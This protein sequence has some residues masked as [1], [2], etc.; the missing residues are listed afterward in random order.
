M[1][2]IIWLFAFTALYVLFVKVASDRIPGA[3]LSKLFLQVLVINLSSLLEGLKDTFVVE[4]VRAAGKAVSRLPEFFGVAVLYAAACAAGMA[5]L[6]GNGAGWDRFALPL[7]A[8][9]GMLLLYFQGAAEAEGHAYWVGSLRALGWVALYGVAIVSVTVTVGPGLVIW[10]PLIMCGVLM[11]LIACRLRGSPLIRLRRGRNAADGALPFFR[12]SARRC[13]TGVM[14]IALGQLDRAFIALMGSRELFVHYFALAEIVSRSAIFYR[15]FTSALMPSL[16]SIGDSPGSVPTVRR[17]VLMTACVTALTP[18]VLMATG[19]YL[20]Y[21]LPMMGECFRSVGNLILIIY[22]WHFA[23]HLAYCLANATG[24]IERH[25]KLLV[26]W[27][28]ICVAAAVGL[29][30]YGVPPL[31]GVV[32]VLFLCRASDLVMLL[33]ATGT[34]W[35]GLERVSW[36]LAAVSTASLLSG[37]HGA[38]VIGCVAASVHAIILMLRSGPLDAGP[39]RS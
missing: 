31:M 25:L 36:F 37:L 34:E 30:S 27:T 13:V 12:R 14:Y 9:A 1:G 3:V 16:A 10:T 28:L 26:V 23:G 21:V 39:L 7:S 18:A 22:S 5:S 15:A 6:S 8:F 19:P 32:V 24:R 29:A 35:R 17:L 2:R 33:C 20:H 4:S 38:F 11:V